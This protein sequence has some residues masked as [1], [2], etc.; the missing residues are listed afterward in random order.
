MAHE[1]IKLP[2]KRLAQTLALFSFL[3]LAPLPCLAQTG[4]GEQIVVIQQKAFS[5]TRRVEFTLLGG[6][7]PSNPF[8]TYVP[9]EGRIAFHLSEGFGLEIGGGYYP[10]FGSEASQGSG[11]YDGPLKNNIIEDLKS[12]P[13]YLGVKL[14]EQQVFYANIDFL[15]T[16]I[17][18]KVQLFGA[19]AITYWEL[20][21]QL[22]AGVTGVYDDERSGRFN[23]DKTNPI[24]LRP[25]INFGV[26]GRLWLTRWLN[27]KIDVREYLF[28]K[29]VGKG[30]LSQHLAIML[31]LSFIVP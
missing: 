16:P 31:G 7:V 8:I 22:G 28:Q 25:T 29:Q 26:S 24:K 4:G 3:W 19:N 1:E 10:S 18:G 2:M 5:K 15:W 13:H 17:F 27:L 14:F 9:F 30:G 20:A 6:V 21:F 23:D 12:H 11:R